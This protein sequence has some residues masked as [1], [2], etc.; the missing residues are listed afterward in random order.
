MASAVLA[1]L[2]AAC[3][4][5]VGSSPYS[6][7]EPMS[8]NIPVAVNHSRYEGLGPQLTQK[9]IRRLNSAPGVTISS[10]AANT[11]RLEITQVT[12]YG[13]AWQV[14]PGAD[15]PE[16]SASRVL[17]VSVEAV[18]E[19]PSPDG[20]PQSKRARFVEQRNFLVSGDQH[21]VGVYE[22]EALDKLTEDIS[23]KITQTLFSEF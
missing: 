12:V 9:V 3:G 21:V 10:G 16:S 6:V 5:S 23:Q 20:R 2:A 4:Y 17:E 7:L 15:R 11:L 13:G 22:N 18:L 1:A 14:T 8:V 19:K